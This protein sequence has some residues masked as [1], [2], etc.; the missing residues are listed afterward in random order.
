MSS[1]SQAS[2]AFEPVAQSVASAAAEREAELR[3]S[4]AELEAQLQ[5]L[6]RADEA[7][8][9]LLAAA[10]GTAAALGR[11]LSCTVLSELDAVAL[12]F[13][14]AKGIASLLCCHL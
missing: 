6:Q 12:V 3:R 14:H 10:A 13:R 7:N 5:A 4:M 1:G 8:R 11:Q 9:V 2:Q